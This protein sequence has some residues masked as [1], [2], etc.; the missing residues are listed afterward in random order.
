MRVR[1]ID[2]REVTGGAHCQDIFECWL[3]KV[4]ELFLG[5]ELEEGGLESV[6]AYVVEEVHRR[7]QSP[8]EWPYNEH[9]IP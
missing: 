4:S 5:D 7:K 9:V 2:R 1:R 6:A 3:E 8:C